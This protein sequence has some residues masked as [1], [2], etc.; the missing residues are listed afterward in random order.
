[1]GTVSLSELGVAT[2]TL[3]LLARADDLTPCADL[4]EV[5]TPVSCEFALAHIGQ[6]DR[7]T[8]R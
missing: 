2:R 1:M 4:A 8:N 3:R 6:I 7:W 5:Y